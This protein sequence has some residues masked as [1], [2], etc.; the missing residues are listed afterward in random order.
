[1]KLL[2]VDDHPLFLSGVEFM[3]KK[4]VSDVDVSVA[5]SAEQALQMLEDS[6]FSLLLLDLNLPNMDGLELLSAMQDRHINLPTLCMSADI[7]A[8][9]IK[10]AMDRGASG[11]VPKTHEPLDMVRAI[12]RVLAGETYLPPEVDVLASVGD[13]SSDEQARMLAHSHGITPRQMAVLELVATGMSNKQIANELSLTEY[14][15]KSHVRALFGALDAGS[16]T[17]CVHRAQQL[18]LL[19]SHSQAS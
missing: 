2:I 6:V 18:G 9:V 13:R 17:A 3:L 11:F 16:R 7:E 5:L 15:I 8:A 1:M 10:N 19:K 12:Y 4:Y 14:T